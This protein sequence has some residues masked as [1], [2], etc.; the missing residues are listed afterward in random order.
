VFVCAVLSEEEP[1]A[2]LMV[3]DMRV[4]VSLLPLLGLDQ[5]SVGPSSL[6]CSP[7]SEQ[8]MSVF[9]QL[10]HKRILKTVCNNKYHIDFKEDPTFRLCYVAVLCLKVTVFI[11]C[12]THTM[13]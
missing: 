1:I 2:F 9:M 5:V 8:I 4:C 11:T 6:K 10:K 13:N 12:I 3:T 7:L